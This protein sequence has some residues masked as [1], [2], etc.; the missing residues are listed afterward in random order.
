M[1]ASAENLP[2]DST[3]KTILIVD[4]DRSVADTFARMLK[5]EGFAVATALSAEA[6]IE[7][8]DSVKPQAIILDMRMPITNGLQF[9]RLVRSKPHLV[10]VP[11]AIVTGDYFL[12]EGIQLELKSLGASIRFKPL[13]L[14][15]LVA[16]AKTLVSA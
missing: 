15:D 13:W 8:A 9:L 14:E 3:T 1:I 4:D 7:L 16:L 6:G 5:L 10:D 2:V 12:P 11:V